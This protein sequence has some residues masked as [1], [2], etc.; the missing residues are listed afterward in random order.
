MQYK[1]SKSEWLRIGRKAKWL[2]KYSSRSRSDSLVIFGI[3]GDLAKKQIFSALHGLSRDKKLDMPVIGFAKESLSK[4]QLIERM[5]SSIEGAKEDIIN[6]I[7]ER[8]QYI[9]GDIENPKSFESLKQS[10]RGCKNPLIYLA[11]PPQAFKQTI[12]GLR[13]SGC[14][15]GAR[16]MIEKPFGE[17][18]ESARKLNAVVHSAF[19][20]EDVFRVDHFLG[21]DGVCSILDIRFDEPDLDRFWNSKNIHSIEISMIEDFDIRGRGEFYDNTGCI[22]DVVQNHLM[23]VLCFLCIEPYEAGDSLRDKKAELLSA[24]EEVKPNNLVTGQ[25]IGYLKEPGVRS[26]SQTETYAAMKLAI[27]NPRWRETTFHIRSGKSMPMTS[28]EVAIRMR[29]I[30][31]IKWPSNCKVEDGLLRI[32][33]ETEQKIP[34]YEKLFS[35]AMDGDA[36]FF[37]RKDEVD[38]QW[39]IFDKVIKAKKETP[40]YPSGTWGPESS[41]VGPKEGWTEPLKSK[42]D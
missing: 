17:D 24:T 4:K 29:R 6:A 23:Q 7:S 8:F 19:N 28:T 40:K 30:P 34:T 32:Q 18:R 39:R 26:S 41:K 9:S 12:I 5:R 42:K 36:T 16:L 15:Q 20:E 2:N 1:L 27:N 25:F 35:M 14:N 11:I 22:K 21:K 10:I 37:S 38:H 13:N 33:L 3:S 31:D